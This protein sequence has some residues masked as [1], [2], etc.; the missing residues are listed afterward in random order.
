MQGVATRP[1]AK[2]YISKVMRTC[3]QNLVGYW[4]LGETGRTARNL[5][6][7]DKLA[8]HTQFIT[9]GTF[10]DSTNGWTAVNSSLS[11]VDPGGAPYLVVTNTASSQGYARQ[12]FVAV[13]GAVYSLTFSH[14]NG[15]GTGGYMIYT[16]S[17]NLVA[18]TS[19]DDAD[20]TAR[21]VTFRAPESNLR[22]RLWVNSSTSGVT[23]L[24]DTVTL[25]GPKPGV[26]VAN[27]IANGSFTSDTASWSAGGGT[28]L[29]SETGGYSGN[30][31]KVLNVGASYAAARQSFTTVVGG[32][33]QVSFYAKQGNTTGALAHIGT[34][35]SLWDV[36]QW[37][38]T[39]TSSWVQ[40]SFIF[41]AQKTTSW[42]RLGVSNA[43]DGNYVLF[44]EVCC[45]P[46]D[47]PGLNYTTDLVTNG[48]FETNTTGWTGASADGIP[49]H[50][51][52]L[53]RVATGYS[54]GYAMKVLNTA[55]DQSYAQYSATTVVGARYQLD[56]RAWKG[57]ANAVVSLVDESGTL[58]TITNTHT[59]APLQ[60]YTFIARATTTNLRI[61]PAT[62]TTNDY[63]YCDD[64]CLVLESL[65]S[66]S[67]IGDGHFGTRYNAVAT[68]DIGN[69]QLYAAFP[70]QAGTLM[71]WARGD[72]AMWTDGTPRWLVDFRVDANNKVQIFRNSTN[73][74]I[75]LCYIAGGTEKNQYFNYP[76][77][78]SREEWFLLVLTWDVVADQVKAWSAHPRIAGVVGTGDGRALYDL[79]GAETS[80]GTWAGT[81]TG[82]YNCIGALNTSL[83]S[84]FD[85]D[86][87]HVALWNKALSRAELEP[88]V[89]VN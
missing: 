21:T 12:N 54:I 53:S 23:T 3:P 52:T 39:L 81:I 26:E 71:C 58:Y 45:I 33:Y 18:G 19:Y 64:I 14:K 74:Q 44:D 60:T 50:A 7:P 78:A 73:D 16:P 87:A 68:T 2:S 55:A 5:I 32:L 59:Y 86:I 56:F 89:E 20:W 51:A 10:D 22:L 85:G 8:P 79:G 17:Y 49:E 35:A 82:T 75:Q 9:N 88:L 67:G 27:L 15:T 65:P 37:G 1:F 84:P 46:L 63:C 42:L 77:G 76:S 25:T 28:T 29:S 40:Y 57:N 62:A 72:T 48:Q 30:C 31:L 69:P 24:F 66:I 80:L 43:T 36:K 70:H 6:R 41:I 13:P 34:L 61:G 38:A 4:P 83:T 11:I 47:L